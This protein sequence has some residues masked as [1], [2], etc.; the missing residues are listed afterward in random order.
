MLKKLGSVIVLACLGLS[1]TS[2]PSAQADPYTAD[3]KTRC[4]VSTPSV[5]KVG[6]RVK[7]RVRVR[8]NGNA[9]PKGTVKITVRRTTGKFIMRKK[10]VKYRGHA[11]RVRTRKIHRPGRYRVKVR[12]RSGESPHFK[13]C[14]A[15]TSFRVRRHFRPSQAPSTGATDEGPTN[16]GPNTTGPGIN[17]VNNVTTTGPS[18]LLPDTGGPNVWWLVL[19]F[20]LVLSGG[21]LVAAA[22]RGRTVQIS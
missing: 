5:I 18:G 8:A 4:S 19:G 9:K 22:R 2:I 12:F 3:I 17:P 6:H 13:S 14:S 16:M 10:I 21:G 15:S 11:V 20:G 7:V 1:F